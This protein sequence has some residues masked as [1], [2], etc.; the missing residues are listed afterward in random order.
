[1]YKLVPDLDTD[2]LLEV[3]DFR[4]SDTRTEPREKNHYVSKNKRLFVNRT[5]NDERKLSLGF[6][7]PRLTFLNYREI[8]YMFKCM[9]A[10]KDVQLTKKNNVIVAPYLVL[11]TLAARGFKFTETL[12]E[13]YFP[14]LFK[15]N[16]KKF[17][18][19]TQIQIM[20]EKLGYAP[21][22]YYTYEFED[23]YSTICMILQSHGATD[24]RSELF[25][26]RPLSDI[27]KSLAEI[28]YRLYLM[29]IGST[30][31]Q[32]SISACASI[33]Q[34]VNTVLL[35]VYMLLT[36]SI[37][38]DKVLTCELAHA[39]PFP[40]DLLK[41]YYSPLSDLVDKLTKLSSCRTNRND[42]QTLL[43]FCRVIREVDQAQPE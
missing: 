21:S 1:M 43:R 34:L 31:V 41:R 20:Q 15:E 24:G 6:F 16:S 28:T 22:N 40:L 11:I 19:V 12:L 36:K 37:T 29:H 4:I 2:V 25:D 7:L 26:I 42:Q 3:G 5:R 13:L 9:D 14:E 27:S 18:F 38:E 39:T 23:Y 32:W 10:I 17:R 35:T 30:S 8:N 33:S